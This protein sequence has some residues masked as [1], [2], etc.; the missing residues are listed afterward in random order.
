MRPGL[1]SAARA[2]W[3]PATIVALLVATSGPLSAQATGSISGQITD[4]SSGR[5]LANAQVFVQSLNVG[6]LTRAN[7]R[8]LIVSVPVGTHTLAVSSIGFGGATE[9]VT[10]TAGETAEVNFQLES[11]ALDLDEIVVTGTGAPTQR[12]RLGQTVTSVTSDAL[13]IAPIT[14]VADALVGRLPGARGLMSGGQ[15]GAGSSIVLRGTSS[16]SQRQGPL[17]YV[18]GVRIENSPESAESVTTDRLADINPQDIDRVEVIKGAAAAT[19]FGTEASSGVIQ[20]FTKRGQVGAPVYSFS[21]DLQHLAFPREF[22]DNCAYDPDA[23]AILC[24][25]PYGEYEEFGYHQ[26]YSL[27]VRGGSEGTRY[28]LSGRIMEEVNPSPNNELSLQSA[29]ASFDFTH[30]ER[31]SSDIG[32]SVVRRNLQTA[33]PGWGDVFGNLMLGNPLQASEGNPNGTFTPTVASLITENY[34]E[35][36]NTLV[37]GQLR[38]QW[39]DGLSSTLQVGYNLVDTR[40][41]G[42]FPQ[43]VVP[44]QVT[45]TRDVLNRRRSTTTIDFSTHWENQL[46]DRLIGTLTFGGQSFAEASSYEETIVREFGSPTLK[47]LSGGAEVTTVTEEFEEV[48][49]AGVFVQGQVGLDDLLF[50]TAGARF[51]GN[52]AFGDDFGLQAYPKAGLSWVVSDHD[53]WNVGFMDE[54]RL[55]AAVGSSG[56]QPGAF[57]AQRTWD[58]NSSVIGGYIEPENLGNPELKPERSTEIEVGLEGGMFD[59]R[60]GVELVYFNQ[61]TRDA[62]LPVPPSPGSGFTEPQLRNLGTLKSWGL[63]LIT[64]TQLIQGSNFGWNLTVSPTYLDQW[65]EDLGGLQDFRLGSRRRFHSLYEGLWPGIWIAPIV[66]PDEPYLLSGPIESL[67]SRRDIAPNILQAADGTDSLAIIGRPQP[68]WTIDIGSVMNFGNFSFR[69]V[70][71]GAGG[72]IVSNETDHLRNALGNS[73]L[74]AQLEF[75]LNDPNTSIEEKRA[76]VDEYGRKHNGVISNTIYDGDYLRWSEANLA[77]RLPETWTA[78]LGSSQM[79]LSLG[80]RNVFVF[81]DYFSDF[82]K[83]WVDPGTRG[84][85]AGQGENVFTQNVDYLKT[86]PPRRFVFSLRATF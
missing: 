11:V 86:P 15:T 63:E 8:F 69:N 68:N 60:F 80:V 81:T 14:G 30:T 84:I 82:K 31:L 44:E 46:T 29:R 7:G 52:S 51:D 20:I 18:D 56:L 67:T 4:A 66:D 53:F 13:E 45:G 79:T 48:I 16:V 17:I 3:I 40:Q 23:S 50:F 10:V 77:V 70:F 55:R 27:S 37:S 19:L 36:I 41:T 78:P 75:A 22:D 25:N 73:P 72:F 26:N 64:Q 58:P 61:T 83:G 76:L 38:Y 85:E 71:E 9:T 21:T 59:G 54:F 43:G 28:Y 35:S 65:V 47:T 42:F 62:L 74:V 2:A 24:E 6:S 39:A 33:T 57:D 49:N 1:P 32:V 12:R 34:Q 5:P